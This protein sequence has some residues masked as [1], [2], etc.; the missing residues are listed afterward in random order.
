[1]AKYII[2]RVGEKYGVDCD[3]E[4]KPVKGD[5]NGSGCHCNF[6]FKKIREDGGYD[7]IIK[8]C[9]PKLSEK[10]KEHIELYGSGNE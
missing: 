1:M 3:F 9:M 7:H 8:H 10:H 4:P 2:Q 5:W 6:S